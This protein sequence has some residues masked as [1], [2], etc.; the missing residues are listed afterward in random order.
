MANLPA[1]LFRPAGAAETMIGKFRRP[2]RALLSMSIVGVP[3]MHL[4]AGGI[5]ALKD[6]ATPTRRILGDRPHIDPKVGGEP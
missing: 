6:L 3:Q 5:L 4:A 2:G 1:K